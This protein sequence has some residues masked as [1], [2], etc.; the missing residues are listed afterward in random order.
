MNGTRIA[1]TLVVVS[2]VASGLSVAGSAFRRAR[3]QRQ[4]RDRSPFDSAA[5]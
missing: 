5:R 4:Q 3:H 2:I 1:R